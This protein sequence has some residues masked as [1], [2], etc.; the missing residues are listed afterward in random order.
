MKLCL[1]RCSLSI[2][3]LLAKRR[4]HGCLQE[5]HFTSAWIVYLSIEA[6]RWK[7]AKSLRFIETELKNLSQKRTDG[8]CMV[9]V[10]VKSK[11]GSDEYPPLEDVH[12]FK[13]IKIA[14]LVFLRIMTWLV[15]STLIILYSSCRCCQLPLY[16]PLN[17]LIS[18]PHRSGCFFSW[19]ISTPFIP[20]P[21]PQMIRLQYEMRS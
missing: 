2:V 9:L 1:H 6:L 8:K 20:S 14:K 16:D 21:Y 11:I 3:F 4:F 15:V 5:P 7:F 10:K 19:H 12:F 18:P 17:H 13:S